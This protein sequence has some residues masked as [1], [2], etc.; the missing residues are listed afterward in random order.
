[1]AKKITINIE[2]IDDEQ[3]LI[4]IKYGEEVIGKKSFK[5]CP[6]KDELNKYIEDCKKGKGI[7]DLMRKI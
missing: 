2:L 7:D 3:W 1:M 4:S 5:E 6:T